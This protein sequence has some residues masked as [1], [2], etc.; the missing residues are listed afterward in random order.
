MEI[1]A[2]KCKVMVDETEESIHYEIG[3]S[4]EVSANSGFSIEV[5][6]GICEYICS[7]IS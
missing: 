3:E 2:G 4:F 6:D 1:I 7:F 5:S